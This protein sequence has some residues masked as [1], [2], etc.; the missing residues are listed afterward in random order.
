MR[1]WGGAAHNGVM[2]LFL[3]SWSLLASLLLSACSPVLD[4][5]EVSAPGNAKLLFPCRPERVARSVTLGSHS[6]PA[7]MLV[8]DAGGSTW[9]ATTFEL[10]DQAQAPELLPLLG[11]QLRLNLAVPAAEPKQAAASAVQVMQGF[12]PG[13]AP[14]T[15][16]TLFLARGRHLYQLVILTPGS[17]RGTQDAGLAQFF[18]GTRWLLDALRAGQSR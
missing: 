11:R 8:C 10:A 3:L 15:A 18:D 17:Q 16:R 14:V 13:G 12:R 4:W 6:L 9:S 5:R 1:G 2:R 7:E